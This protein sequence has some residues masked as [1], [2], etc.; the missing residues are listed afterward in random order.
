MGRG[1]GDQFPELPRD[2]TTGGDLIDLIEEYAKVL[3]QLDLSLADDEVADQFR[4]VGTVE[5]NDQQRKFAAA[6]EA[7]Q[8]RKVGLPV[9]KHAEA[10]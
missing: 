6:I 4:V 1:A 9:P 8:G 3:E 5:A 2:S 7:L 10:G